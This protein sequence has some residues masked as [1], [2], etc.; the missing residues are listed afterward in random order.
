MVELE[1]QS[2]REWFES[3]K[4]ISYEKGGLEIVVYIGREP[5]RVVT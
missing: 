1:S 2:M 5:L 3:F 4:L